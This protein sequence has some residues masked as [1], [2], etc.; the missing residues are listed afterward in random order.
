MT[1]K[2]RKYPSNYVKAD[3]NSQIRAYKWN[4]ADYEPYP[5]PEGCNCVTYSPDM[6]EIVNCISC[7]REL[8]FG[9]T[10]TSHQYHTKGGMGFAEYE[11]CYYDYMPEYLRQK[12]AGLD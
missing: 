12:D 2:F 6:D 8:P 7:F 5:I 9:E 3:T 4:G 1:R 10:Y 11:K